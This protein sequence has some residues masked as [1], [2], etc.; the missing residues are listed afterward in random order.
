MSIHL[1]WEKL[2]TVYQELIDHSGLAAEND[3]IIIMVLSDGKPKKAVIKFKEF[4][5]FFWTI[6]ENKDLHVSTL[7]VQDKESRILYRHKQRTSGAE[8]IP[9]GGHAG[10]I[11]S[12]CALTEEEKDSYL[13]ILIAQIQGYEQ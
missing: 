9:D 11:Q 10:I 3:I 8:E 13:R 2:R 6:S 12:W 4:L 7:I 5:N 1:D